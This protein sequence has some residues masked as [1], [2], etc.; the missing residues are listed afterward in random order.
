M[1]QNLLFLAKKCWLICN[2]FPTDSSGY[3]LAIFSASIKDVKTA[4]LV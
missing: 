1:A 4:R 3:N 2:A